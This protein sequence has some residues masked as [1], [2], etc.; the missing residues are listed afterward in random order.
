MTTSRWSIAKL[1]TLSAVRFCR[2]AASHA[3]HLRRDRL[4][5][6]YAIDQGGTYTIFRET[7]SDAERDAR[8]VVL[9]VGFRLRLLRAYPSPHW[10]FQR[11]C[12][13]TTPFWSGLRGFRVKLWMVDPMSK[14]YLGIYDWAG[15]ENAK[16]YVNALVR[17]LRPLST[18]GSV[19]Y[20][21]YPDQELDAYLRTRKHG[22]PVTAAIREEERAAPESERF[23][24]SRDEPVSA[25]RTGSA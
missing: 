12:I 22:R 16:V 20:R 9:V 10:I 23:L 17:V 14:N 5:E 18:C 19:W 7:V 15:E 11:L 8:S 3:L 25:A 1:A 6:R 2:L 24:P 13:L 4:G 21:L